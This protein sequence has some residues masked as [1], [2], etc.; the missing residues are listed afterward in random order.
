MFPCWASDSRRSAYVS[1]FT[2]RRRSITWKAGR[3]IGHSPI[4]FGHPLEYYLEYP[5]TTGAVID[6]TATRSLNSPIAFGARRSALAFLGWNAG[7]LPPWHTF[8]ETVTGVG[9]KRRA[10]ME[11]LGSYVQEAKGLPQQTDRTHP[12]GMKRRLIGCRGRARRV[13]DH[14]PISAYIVT[15]RIEFET[16]EIS[17]T[18][19]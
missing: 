8:D 14:T 9:P 12:S 16:L 18:K 15:V 5:S 17:M 13:G 1:R 4:L 19:A 7:S 6:G 2:S 11:G 3:S 10:P